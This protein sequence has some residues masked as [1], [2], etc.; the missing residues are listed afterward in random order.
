[1]AVLH[2]H[3]DVQAIIQTGVVIGGFV[4]T[5]SKSTPSLHTRFPLSL[6]G[7]AVRP[8]PPP[9]LPFFSFS[10]ARAPAS[11]VLELKDSYVGGL[12]IAFVAYLDTMGKLPR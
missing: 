9:L 3:A 7:Q 12:L 4:V 8:A 5:V 1:M 6:V 10:A 2:F 11:C